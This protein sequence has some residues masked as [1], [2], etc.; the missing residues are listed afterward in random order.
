MLLS[1]W[2]ENP[3]LV[4]PAPVWLISR[5][6]ESLEEEAFPIQYNKW[7]VVQV[8]M[9][10]N[11]QT[12]QSLESVDPASSTAGAFLRRASGKQ[13]LPSKHKS[14]KFNQLVD[15]ETFCREFE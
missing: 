9:E 6:N 4:K 14:C 5:H 15:K 7:N 11:L 1:R 2:D 10:Q 13:M 8:H 12:I 3:A